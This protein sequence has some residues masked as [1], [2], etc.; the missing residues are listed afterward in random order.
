MIYNGIFVGLSSVM[1]VYPFYDDKQEFLSHNKDFRQGNNILRQKQQIRY[2]AG[3]TF[4]LKFGG[5]ANSPRVIFF[6][7]G[8][9]VFSRVVTVEYLTR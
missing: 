3:K 1:P 2:K 7:L 5:E 4:Q 9:K 6:F 8:G